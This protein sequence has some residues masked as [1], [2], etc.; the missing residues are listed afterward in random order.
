MHPVIVNIG[1]ESGASIVCLH[2]GAPSASIIGIDIDM[3]K[4][5]VND[6]PVFFVETDSGPYAEAWD[7]DIDL[8]F[9]DGDHTYEGVKADLAW[10]KHVKKGGHIV[11]HDCYDWPPSPPKTEHGVCPGVNIAVQEWVDG[12][13][14]VHGQSWQEDRTVDTSRVFMRLSR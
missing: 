12:N 4:S 7:R 2:H 10:T 9:I 11:F 5:E 3:S 6:L 13:K 14:H 8:L 1:V